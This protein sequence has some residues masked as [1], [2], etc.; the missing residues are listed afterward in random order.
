[1]GTP[2]AILINGKVIF[3]I[4]KQPLRMKNKVRRPRTNYLGDLGYRHSVLRRLLH[5]H[6]ESAGLCVTSVSFYFLFHK[7]P[8]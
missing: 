6:S 1:M 5:Q 4:Y 2:N 7:T 8:C 3:K